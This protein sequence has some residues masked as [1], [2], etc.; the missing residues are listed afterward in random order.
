MILSMVKAIP[1]VEWVGENS[2]EIGYRVIPNTITD[3]LDEYFLKEGTYD[4]RTYT[5]SLHSD[6]SNFL[7]GEDRPI[8]EPANGWLTPRSPENF[9]VSAD[10]LEFRTKYPIYKIKRANLKRYV[11]VKVYDVTSYGEETK[12]EYVAIPSTIVP[13]EYFI[14]PDTNFIFERDY[15]NSL[16]NE[17]TY[18]EKGG[19]FYYEQGTNKIQNLQYRAPTW[20]QFFAPTQQA[21][22]VILENYHAPYETGSLDH[23]IKPEYNTQALQDEINTYVEANIPETLVN[24]DFIAYATTSS[25][26]NPDKPSGDVEP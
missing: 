23:I 18:L 25:F 14:E 16:L 21:W 4:P 12:L 22:R 24:Y 3:K 9:T 11:K 19:S 7:A 20:S 15:W 8:T 5:T 6:V 26:D 2:F 1:F 13:D 17:E 10:V